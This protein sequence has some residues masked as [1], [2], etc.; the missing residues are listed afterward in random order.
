MFG[1]LFVAYRKRD[2]QA[3]LLDGRCA[4]MGAELEL[5]DVI[6]DNL[7]CPFHH[8]QFGPDGRCESIPSCSDIPTCARI[9]AFPVVERHGYL[10][11][12]NGAEPHFPLPF[13]PNADPA[14]FI[15][16]R[17]LQFRF[18]APWFMVVGNAF[19]IQHFRIVHDRKLLDNPIIDC[20]HAYAR[21]I[22]CQV[23]VVGNT[24]S[25]RFI[26]S[27]IGDKVEVEH[28][29]WQGNVLTTHAHFRRTDSYIYFTA[30][31]QE[32][33]GA[34]L[35]AITLLRRGNRRGSPLRRA[36]D[37][38]SLGVRRWLTGRFVGHEADQIRSLRYTPT[39]LVETDREMIEYFQ[40]VASLPQG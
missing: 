22:R 33:G 8:W 2:G 32:D 18:D 30:I 6:G 13:F 9:S 11:F 40:W 34:T 27:F 28:H 17:P 10:F 36:T 31:P 4:H 20:P 35:E 38:L 1:R 37:A 16:G 23:S 14:E 5:G 12:F 3:V 25:D 19:D 7:R 24:I 29:V 21:R 39:T 26:R 15:A